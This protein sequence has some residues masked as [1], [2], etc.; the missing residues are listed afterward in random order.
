[1]ILYGLPF[2]SVFLAGAHRR[3]G[4]SGIEH[5]RLTRGTTRRVNQEIVVYLAGRT[6]EQRAARRKHVPVSGRDDLEKALE[7]IRVLCADTRKQPAC[8]QM[9]HARAVSLWKKPTHFKV[10]LEVAEALIAKRK[11]SYASV[12]RIVRSR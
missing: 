11:L 8:F 4:S 7:W 2:Y 5:R 9:L 12:K 3:W 6:A 10:V 1:M